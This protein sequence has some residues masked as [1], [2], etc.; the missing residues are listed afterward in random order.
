MI[1]T[2]NKER[3]KLDTE[4]HEIIFQFSM[5]GMIN[6]KTDDVKE[7]LENLLSNIKSSVDKYEDKMTDIEL[8]SV[9][10]RLIKDGKPKHGDKH[11]G[12]DIVEVPYDTWEQLVRTVISKQNT[13]P[14]E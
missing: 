14:N 9:C 12:G 11:S 1:S 2:K 5:S 13:E 4:L 10:Q 8:L 7:A 6:H 3:E